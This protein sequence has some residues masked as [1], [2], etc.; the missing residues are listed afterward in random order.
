M[1]I[2]KVEK[3]SAQNLFVEL[4]VCVALIQSIERHASKTSSKYILFLPDGK[5]IVPKKSALLNPNPSHNDPLNSSVSAL[6]SS[7][8]ILPLTISL[9]LQI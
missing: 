3:A 4:K 6:K 5:H 8:P 2:N 9:A 7:H 1:S